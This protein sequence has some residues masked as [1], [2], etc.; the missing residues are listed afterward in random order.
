MSESPAPPALP[1]RGRWARWAGVFGPAFVISMAYVD[2][3]NFATNTA[4][5]ATYGYLLLWVVAAAN[6]MAMFVQYLSA[7]LGVVT[8]R[9]LADQCRLRC[10]RSVRYVL[11]AQ[12]EAVAIA[13]DLAEL[14]GGAIAL[15]LLFGVPLV[16][17]VCIT[18]AVA[19]LL[20]TLAPRGRHRFETA[21][22]GMLLVIL[23]G[24]LYQALGAGLTT[25]AASGF[26][27]QFSG[28]DSLLLA[29]GIIGA[30]VMPHVIYLHSALTRAPGT[31]PRKALRR[32]RR[33]ITGALACAGIANMAMLVVAASVFH[34][35]AHVNVSTLQEAH[36]GLHTYV[37][38]AV[39]AA[40]ALTLLA[41]GLAS[42]SVGTYAGQVVMEGFLQRRIPLAIR[43]GATLIPALA[44]LLAGLEPTRALIFSQVVLSFGIPFALIPLII[45]TSRRSI[46][47]S[48]VNHPLTVVAAVAVAALI[49]ILNLYL[50]AR[51]FL[52]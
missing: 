43:R 14:I 46:M 40:F 51:P 1:T 50:L 36:Q 17:G 44:L 10:P 3:G 48:L 9:S 25:R 29:T 24:F 37:G 11:W 16:P 22:A 4:A 49:S 34:D 20:L 2:P 38:P 13:T 47:G 39:A 6:I 31:S 45:L 18:A 32:G 30:T 19:M 5:G 35:K 8:G 7:K 41:S 23:A 42:S 28:D 33:E 26:V 21:M 52:D 15:N 27:P 12:A